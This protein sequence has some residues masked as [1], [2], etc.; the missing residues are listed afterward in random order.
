MPLLNPGPVYL[1]STAWW[2]LQALGSSLPRP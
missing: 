1:Q 2:R